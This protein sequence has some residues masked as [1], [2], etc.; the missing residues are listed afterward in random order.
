MDIGGGLWRQL[1]HPCVHL[2]NLGHLFTRTIDVSLVR[3]QQE[4]SFTSFHCSSVLFQL[5][6]VCSKSLHNHV[7]FGPTFYVLGSCYFLSFLSHSFFCRV[8]SGCNPRADPEDRIGGK[9]GVW[10]VM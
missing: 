1:F 7:S 5:L 6:H 9:S 10:A 3:A 2:H 8:V 4:I